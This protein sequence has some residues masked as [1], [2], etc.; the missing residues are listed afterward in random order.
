[1]EYQ[2]LA[3]L[4]L[5]QALRYRS[6][7]IYRFAQGGRWQS[8]TW[9]EALRQVR[10]IALGL[11]S[12]GVRRGDRIAILSNNRVE[13]NLVDWANICIGAL[14]VPIYASSPDS[15]VHRILSDCEPAVVFVESWE[16]SEQLKPF[17]GGHADPG[18]WVVID[19]AGSGVQEDVMTLAQRLRPEDDLTIIYTS[20]TTG[21]PK[22]V[23]TTHGH[24]LFMVNAVDAALPS[25][26]ADVTLHFL[27]SAHSLG[28]LEHF[29]G[30]AKGWTLGYAR[31]LDALAKDLRL[32]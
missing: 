5:S 2:S 21:E 32:L 15:Q 19:C 3:A 26:D 1:M 16:R 7:V 4:F 28:R 17:F 31:S 14:T 25:G 29:M 30:V 6:K 8:Y 22:G 24:Y 23:L 11:I 18:R 27:P 13:W 9:D 12:L 20:G 10:D